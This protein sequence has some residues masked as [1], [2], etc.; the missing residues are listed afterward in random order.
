MSWNPRCLRVGNLKAEISSVYNKLLG[1]PTGEV[2]TSKHCTNHFFEM[3]H[4]L[5]KQC[6]TNIFLCLLKCY[7]YNYAWWKIE[8]SQRPTYTIQEAFINFCELLH[9]LQQ[10]DFGPE[11]FW[12][13][14]FQTKLQLQARVQAPW[15]FGT[16]QI[17]LLSSLKL[18]RY[19]LP[20]KQ[21]LDCFQLLWTV[22]N[23]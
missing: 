5:K 19:W 14:N 10:V 16:M 9:T 21:S 13:D 2:P 3:K 1:I 12:S 4:C 20:G 23:G 18:D 17:D 7:F 11:H 8:I 22:L 6:K 15:N